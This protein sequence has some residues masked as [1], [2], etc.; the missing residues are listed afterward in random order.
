[1]HVTEQIS[2]VPDEEVFEEEQL[3]R[4]AACRCQR[5]GCVRAAVLPDQQ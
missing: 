1:M 5:K 3:A 2:Q 4:L